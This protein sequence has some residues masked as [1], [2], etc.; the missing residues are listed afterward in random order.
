MHSI[1][2]EMRLSEHTT[3]ICMNIECHRLSP[4]KMQHNESTFWICKFYADIRGGS[5]G[6]GRQTTVGLSTVDNGSFSDF[7]DHIIGNFRDKAGI[8][9]Y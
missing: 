2:E 4:A 8:I 3:K 7:A 5:L 1:A 6:K 9:T